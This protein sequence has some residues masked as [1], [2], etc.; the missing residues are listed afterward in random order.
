VDGVP[1]HLKGS[2]FEGNLNGDG[3]IEEA[4]NGQRIV[5]VDFCIFE[6]VVDG[7]GEHHRSHYLGVFQ[8]RDVDDVQSVLK[9]PAGGEEMLFVFTDLPESELLDATPICLHSNTLE[10]L[11]DSGFFQVSSVADAGVSG[12]ALFRDWVGRWIES[13]GRC[14]L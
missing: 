11:V 3:I 2:V 6:V 8:V 1:Q 13:G 7:L 14:D 12:V 5:P 4:E 9:L 10:L